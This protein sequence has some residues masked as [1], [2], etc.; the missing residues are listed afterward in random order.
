MAQLRKRVEVKDPKALCNLALDYGDGEFGLSVDLTKC[1]ELLRES[2][3]LGCVHAQCSLGDF[4]HTGDKGL[5][6]NEEEARKYFKE[7]AVG[8]HVIARHNLGNAEAAVGDYI[9]AM[10]HW[11]V[12][13][14]GGLTT[15]MV[16]LIDCFESGILKHEDFAETLQAMYHSRA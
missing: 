13:A 8:G 6:R 11:R 3:E 7:A 10:R 4:Y 15:S 16:S 12:S 1:I 5:E 14:S 2:A 9:A